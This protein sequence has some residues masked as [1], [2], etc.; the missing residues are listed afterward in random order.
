M[1]KDVTKLTSSEKVALQNAMKRVRDSGEF[2][3]L[4]NFHGSPLTMC[5]TRDTFTSNPTKRLDG[6]CCPHGLTEF[7]PWHRLL[8]TNMDQA[9]VNI[10]VGNINVCYEKNF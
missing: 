5:D 3:K 1:R 7:L 4:A 9:S 2:A 8:I 6:G 10:A